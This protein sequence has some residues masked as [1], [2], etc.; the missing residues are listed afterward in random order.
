M[1]ESDDLRT[2]IRDLMT[3]FDRK[4]DRIDAR[5]ERQEAENR[6]Y[7]QDLHERTGEI[8]AEGRAGRAA[9][10][11]ILDRLDGNGGSAAPGAV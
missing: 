9:L 5:M 2:F 6:A 10:F 8:L 3:R 1:S 7:F 4:M 11:R